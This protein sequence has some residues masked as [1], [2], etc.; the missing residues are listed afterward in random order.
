VRGQALVGH[1]H[2]VYVG[3]GS[4]DVHV[5]LHVNRLEGLTIPVSG[6]K[7]LAQIAK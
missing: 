5:M 1:N 6:N 7:Y 3:D 2:L 4:S